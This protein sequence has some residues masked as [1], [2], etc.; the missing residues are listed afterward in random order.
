M[1]VSSILIAL[2]GLCACLIPCYGRESA[3]DAWPASETQMAPA[4]EAAHGHTD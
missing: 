1:L 3:E 4:A 2:V